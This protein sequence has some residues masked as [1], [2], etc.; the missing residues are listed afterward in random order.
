MSVSSKSTLNL[1]KAG[2]DSCIAERRDEMAVGVAP[3]CLP[4]TEGNHGGIALTQS[5]L[6]SN[7]QILLEYSCRI[8]YLV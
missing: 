1:N 8:S 2:S 6:F 5:S 7:A 3:P 4:L